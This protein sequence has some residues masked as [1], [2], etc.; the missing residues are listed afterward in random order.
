MS[1]PGDGRSGVG[2]LDPT[3]S[4]SVSPSRHLL[5]VLCEM[6]PIINDTSSPVSKTLPSETSS[7]S[8]SVTPASPRALPHLESSRTTKC[9]C[10]LEKS[11]FPLLHQAPKL[12]RGGTYKGTC[13]YLG[14]FLAKI[15]QPAS[16]FTGNLRACSRSES[17]FGLSPYH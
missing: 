3:G 1:F 12:A 7:P 17:A 10:L 4:P 13:T 5:S 2:V 8:P 15:S 6:N 9:P 14:C 16:F 11:Q